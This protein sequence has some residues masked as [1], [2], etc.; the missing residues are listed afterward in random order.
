[1]SE[2]PRAELTR[3]ERDHEE[4]ERELGDGPAYDDGQWHLDE[5][6]HGEEPERSDEPE[7]GDE[8]DSDGEQ[9]H[10]GE[11]ER[12]EGQEADGERAH[13]GE[14]EHHDPRR[15]GGE[16]TRAGPHVPGG[17]EEGEAQ[18]RGSRAT[19]PNRREGQPARDAPQPEG[20]AREGGTR[21]MPT[22]GVRGRSEAEDRHATGV[23]RRRAEASDGGSRSSR[24][25]LPRAERY[26]GA[27]GRRGGAESTVRSGAP[28]RALGGGHGGEHHSPE[29][30]R[31]REGRRM[32]GSRSPHRQQKWGGGEPEENHGRPTGA[33][34]GRKGGR[35][36]DACR[37]ANGCRREG[38]G[39]HPQRDI[40]RVKP[41]RG[42]GSR[43]ITRRNDDES[44][45]EGEVVSGDSRERCAKG[46]RRAGPGVAAWPRGLSE[47]V[48]PERD[49]N[50]QGKEGGM[51][52]RGEGQVSLG[53]REEEVG[54]RRQG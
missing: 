44:R 2:D 23:Q 51:G 21:T 12:D 40:S 11:Q 27:E 3:E 16:Q 54:P 53:E 36:Q 43:V 45:R 18:E 7:Y 29:T 50:E 13:G 35:K 22:R 15:N 47:P 31:R 30:R 6:A 41:A 28:P 25:P 39:R 24:E 26:G 17:V 34:D 46:S 37:Q 38:S 10:G 33:V 52:D 32:E 1:M 8:Q 20:Q 14:Q 49:W 42:C 5:Q 48:W 4:A 19:G 9:E